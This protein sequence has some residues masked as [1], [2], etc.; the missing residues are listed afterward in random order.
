MKK[1][2]CGLLAVV[3]CFGLCG[4][5]EAVPVGVSNNN[6]NYIGFSL[7]SGEKC[8]YYCE[9]TKIVYVIFGECNGYDG[10]GYMSPYYA[11]NGFPYLY[12]VNERALVEIDF[13]ER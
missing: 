6:Q 2:F 10:Y 7:I 13:S 4:C 3:L 11:P 5:Y 9:E 8:L 12:D 1:I